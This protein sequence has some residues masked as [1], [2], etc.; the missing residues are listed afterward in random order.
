MALAGA[1]GIASTAG[2]AGLGGGGGGGDDDFA[3]AVEGLNLGENWQQRRFGAAENWPTEDRLKT[4]PRDAGT[5]TDSTAWKSAVE[6]KAWSPP[7]GWKDT[8]AGDVDTIEIINHG[9]VNMQYDP[10]TL[11]VHEYF[12]EVTGIE[13]KPIEIG[14]DQA[15]QRE[16]QVLSSK[17]SSPVLMNITGGLLPSFVQQGW[18]QTTDALYPEGVW[19]P[20]IPALQ[21]LVQW[22]IG[23]SGKT[24]TYGSV[25]IAEGTVG[26][27]RPDLME[28]QGLDPSR[29]QGEWSWDLLEEAMEAFK[30]T[31]VYAYA[32]YAGTPTYLSYSYR[33]LLYQQGGRMVQDD[34]TVKVDTDASIRVVEKMK[35][36][37]DNGWVPGDVINYG[38][39]D[40]VDL[41]LSGQLAFTTAFTDFVSRA[42]GEFEPNT[43]YMP[44]LPPAANAGPSPAN[45]ALVDPNATSINPYA[46]TANKL[47]AMLYGDLKLSYV[48]QWWELT[49]E[50][51]LSYIDSVYNDAAEAGA[52]RYGDVFGAAVQNG[53]AEMFPQMNAVFQRMLNPV[54]SA[55]VGDI[56][57]E[58][59][60][61]QV[62]T[63]V[64][65]NINK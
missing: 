30:D 49:Y 48:A 40:I 6:N 22:D 5:W 62:Q 1:A 21:S 54:Q 38:E 65:E 18:I 51:N 58:E 14:V 15:N 37:R 4:P 31:G 36:W 45:S 41:Y 57:P 20:Y 7:D 16:Q 19:E 50:S 3:S 43:E 59:A 12:E 27:L 28:E 17:E 13:V 44:V 47:A 34:G 46:P 35:E 8:A 24:Q 64:D 32:Y 23:P 25:N 26:H 29:F 63:Y 11:A 61:S 2:C 60:M 33:E 9:A 10:A 53:V 39:G 52:L 55:I 56:T 42:L